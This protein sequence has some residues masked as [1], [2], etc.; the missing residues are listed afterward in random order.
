MEPKKIVKTIKPAKSTTISSKTDIRNASAK[1]GKLLK[2]IDN[3]TAAVV[4]MKDQLDK[5]IGSITQASNTVKELVSG[6]SNA[7]LA[8]PPEPPKVKPAQS[9]TVKTE[10]AKPTKA[11][12]AAK[13]PP[14][15]TP[16]K[17]TKKPE[18]GKAV[19]VERPPLRQLIIDLVN[20]KQSIKSSDIYPVIEAKAK[21]GGFPVWSRQ[22]VYGLLKKLT[23]QNE[24]AKTGDGSDAVYSVPVMRNTV[25][26][27]DDA[28]RLINKVANSSAVAAVQ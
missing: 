7:A 16:V 20:D 17:P 15:S 6:I 14:T 23:E 11:P 26:S 21:T 2:G 8:T 19:M 27:D 5:K 1:V 22:S 28:D 25:A 3:D 24:F 9:K 13:K 18:N 4:K 10:A 12:V